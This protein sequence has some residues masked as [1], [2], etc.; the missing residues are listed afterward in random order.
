MQLK[1]SQQLRL[2]RLYPRSS[3]KEG[4]RTV[5]IPR[6]M[7]ARVGGSPLRDT[8]VLQWATDVVNQVMLDNVIVDT[9]ANPPRDTSRSR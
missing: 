7:T 4:T 5:L 9:G 1:E 2:A 6:P 3:Y 8:E